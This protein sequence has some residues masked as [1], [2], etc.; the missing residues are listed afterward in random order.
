MT[1]ELHDLIVAITETV[2][3]KRE[4]ATPLQHTLNNY[5][6]ATNPHL[7]V[8]EDVLLHKDG[9]MCPDPINCEGLE[10]GWEPE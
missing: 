5:L 8:F 1:E 2:L 3:D 9:G 6:A 10:A 4:L 7:S